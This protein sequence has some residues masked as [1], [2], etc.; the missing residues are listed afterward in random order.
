MVVALPLINIHEDTFHPCGGQ[1]VNHGAACEQ[2]NSAIRKDP[3]NSSIMAK[4]KAV[5]RSVKA[6][7]FGRDIMLIMSNLALSLY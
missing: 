6:H 7:H 1:E 5:E 2:C 3:P 4:H